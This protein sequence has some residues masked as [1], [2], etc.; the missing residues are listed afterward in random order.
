MKLNNLEEGILSGN[1]KRLLK[2]LPQNILNH[3]IFEYLFL[4][5]DY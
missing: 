2:W 1:V 4:M 5:V 3:S